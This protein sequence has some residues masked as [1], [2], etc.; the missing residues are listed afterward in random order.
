MYEIYDKWP[1]IANDAYSSCLEIVDCENV[2]H[3]V[4]A[5]MGG[6]GTIGDIFSAILS[7]TSLHVTVVKGYVLPNIVKSKALVITTSVSGNTPETLSII[8]Q[9]K[10]LNCKTISFSS[11]GKMKDYCLENNLIHYTIKELHS[12][13][14]SLTSFLYSM[15][16]ILENLIPI[17]KNDIKESIMELKKINNQISSNSLT[18]DNTS[19]D[20]AKWLTDNTMIYYP[21]GLQAVAIRFKNSL[22]EN[23]KVFA[24]SEDVVEASHNGIV[25][26]EKPSNFKPVLLR[27]QDD[28]IK[29][30]ERWEIFKEYFKDKHIDYKEIISIK[31]SILSKIITLIYLLDYATIYKAVMLKTDPTPVSSID[32]IKK[33]L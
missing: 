6:S 17:S 18:D 27:G 1:D 23:A 16:K 25:S 4:F 30:K 5:G 2:D 32:Y 11:G 12:P 8:E 15:L 31:G 13:R 3:I 21:L 20:L 26:W 14:A 29:T 19:V 33:K 28:Y 10:K 22:Q 24:A 9:A 7:K